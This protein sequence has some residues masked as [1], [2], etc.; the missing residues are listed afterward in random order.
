MKI[1]LQIPGVSEKQQQQQQQKQ[2]QQQQCSRLLIL[3]GTTQQCNIFRHYK[4][5][6]YLVVCDVSTPYVKCNLSYESKRND[7]SN[8]TEMIKGQM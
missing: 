6:F 5:N 4:Y 3:N 7:E 1:S 2:Q 8:R